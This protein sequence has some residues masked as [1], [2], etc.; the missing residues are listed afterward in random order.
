MIQKKD[1][2]IS[3]ESDPAIV[4]EDW[5][6][7]ILECELTLLARKSESITLSESCEDQTGC[8]DYL[9]AVNSMDQE[10][11]RSLMPKPRDLHEF[12]ATECVATDIYPDSHLKGPEKDIIVTISDII[13]SKMSITEEEGIALNPS[14]SDMDILQRSVESS[15]DTTTT[16]VATG[17]KS[18]TVTDL[19]LVREI[20]I[21]NAKIEEL[22]QE[23]LQS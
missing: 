14:E 3:S 9:E 8:S 19:S 2:M 23:Q 6:N 5:L 15:S 21:M 22:Q 12:C 18:S 20:R 16:S 10:D 1:H 11:I 7:D 13:E 17:V 4:K